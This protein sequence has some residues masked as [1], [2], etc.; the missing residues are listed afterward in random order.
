VSARE[1]AS[2]PGRASVAIQIVVKSAGE[3]FVGTSDNIGVGGLFVVTDRRLSPGD[4]VALELML[5]D[6]LHPTSLDAEVRWTRE[7]DGR[8]A[9]CGM[10]FVSPSIGA[11]VAL[12][13]LLRRIGEDQ[14]RSP[15]SE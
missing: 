2:R 4:R 6:H 13:D 9:G 8:P 3:S 11:T 1:F 10:R 15:R 14:L 5:P 7:G 12:H